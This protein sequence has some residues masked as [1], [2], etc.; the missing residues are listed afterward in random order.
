VHRFDL[1][2]ESRKKTTKKSQK[3]LYFPY[4]GGTPTGPIRP[5]SCMVGDVHDVITC[6]KFETEIFVGYNFTGGRIFDP[7]IRMSLNMTT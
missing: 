5:K 6:A 1:G 7:L 4:L 3:V 2:V